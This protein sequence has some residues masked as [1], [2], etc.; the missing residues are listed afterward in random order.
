MSF[1][2]PLYTGPAPRGR[3]HRDTVPIITL[4]DDGD[5]LGQPRPSPQVICMSSGTQAFDS[6]MRFLVGATVDVS[7]PSG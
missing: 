2:G 7:E 4:D 5:V 1:L 6:N 3:V